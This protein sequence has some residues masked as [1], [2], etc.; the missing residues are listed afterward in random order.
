MKRLLSTL[1]I[2]CLAFSVTGCAWNPF[3]PSPGGTEFSMTADGS[4][5]YANTGRDIDHASGEVT[6]PNGARGKF[7]VA[8]SKGGDVT[9][10]AVGQQAAINMALIAAMPKL[11]AADIMKLLPLLMGLPPAPVP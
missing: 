8:G 1:A 4:I 7:R 3:Q 2:V 11:S 10:A 5:K 9:T 6:F